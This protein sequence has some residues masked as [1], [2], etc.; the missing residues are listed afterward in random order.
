MNLVRRMGS[1][2]G[3][4]RVFLQPRVRRVLANILALRFLVAAR[5]VTT[6]GRVLTGEVARRGQHAT[7]RLRSTGLPVVMQHGRDVEALFEIFQRG[8]YEPPQMLVPRLSEDQVRTIVDVGANVGM[9]SSWALGRWPGASVVSIEPDP[10]NLV[11][12]RRWR[13]ALPDDRVALVEAAASTRAGTLAFVSGL[14]GGSMV[15]DSGDIVVASIDIFDL[16][17]T[18]DF[19]KIDIEGGEWP[20]LADPRLAALEQLTVVM[21]YHRVGAPSLPAREAAVRLLEAAGF[22]TGF[23]KQNYWGHGTLWAWKG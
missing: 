1:A 8:E 11:E 20:I 9:F 3:L 21:E 7:Y 22:R 16:L 6:P 17:R 4:R 12:L 13:A 23:G 14:G 10:G 18:A 15:S 5:V 2:P 19:V